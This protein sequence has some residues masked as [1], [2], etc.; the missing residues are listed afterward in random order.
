VGSED[1][2]ATSGVSKNR[3]G[4]YY[5]RKKVPKWLE[6]PTAEILD[7]GKSRQIFLKRSLDTKDPRKPNIRAKHVLIEFDRILAQAGALTVT[8]PCAPR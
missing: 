7:N 2:R 5:L 1:V 8:G 4:V 3:H 6:Q